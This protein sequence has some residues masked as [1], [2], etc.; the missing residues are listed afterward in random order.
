MTVVITWL[1]QIGTMQLDGGN[2]DL[3]TMARLAKQA[4]Q[5]LAGAQQ[6]P[7]VP[8]STDPVVIVGLEPDA[9]GAG[10]GRSSI[11]DPSQGASPPKA[12]STDAL[13]AF[14]SPAPSQPQSAGLSAPWHPAAPSG[15]GG[16]LQARGGSGGPSAALTAAATPGSRGSRAAAHS[17]ST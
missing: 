17:P 3:L 15:G 16:A 13:S 4:R 7:P 9:P 12:Q 8:K 5:G 11:E 14:L 10:G 2:N 1:A 6:A